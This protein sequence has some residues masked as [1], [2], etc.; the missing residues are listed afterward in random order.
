MDVRKR[1][2]LVLELLQARGEVSVADLSHQADVSEMTIRRDLETLERQGVLKRTRGGATSAVSRSYEPPFAIRSKLQLDEKERIGRLA[3]TLIGEGET[4]I[5]DAG[6]TTLAMA[7]ALVGARNITVCTPSLHIAAALAD[8]PGI[9]LILTGG[10]A[11]LGERSLIGDIAEHTFDRLR[12]DVLFLT[13]A[14]VDGDAGL[15]EWNLDDV[16]VKRAAVASARRCVVVADS[17][18]LGQVGFAQICPLDR[19]DLLITDDTASD[20]QLEAPRAA[21]V[22]VLLA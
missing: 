10:I 4:A 7:Q 17:T 11:R 3:A 8:E 14:G 20:R 2:E 13:V 21:G 16:R 12:F 15:T 5:L 9:R 19:V 18:K 1:Q 6:T 22:D